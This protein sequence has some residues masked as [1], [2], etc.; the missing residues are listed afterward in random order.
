MT[1]ADHAEGLNHAREYLEETGALLAELT[2]RE[3]QLITL[4]EIGEELPPMDPALKTQEHMVPGCASATYVITE[5]KPDERVYFHM[6]SESFISK[7]YL[8]ILME[9]LNGC[10]AEDLLKNVEPYVQ[11]FAE[12]AG[13]RLSMLA[14]RANVFERVF[15]F[16][17]KQILEQMA[18]SE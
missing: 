11:A 12:D 9:A 5:I 2:S 6:D 13:V 18:S 8:Y 1:A 14:S 10:T 15:R 17:Q 7:G 4:R 3:E 16:M